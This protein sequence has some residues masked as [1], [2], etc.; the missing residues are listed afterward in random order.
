M[1]ANLNHAIE[2]SRHGKGSKH[3]ITLL[4]D[5]SNLTLW[6]A[7][8]IS[9]AKQLSGAPLLTRKYNFTKELSK[10]M[11]YGHLLKKE[12]SEVT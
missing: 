5:K 2:A 12:K 7:S 1:V 9:Y 11:G 4:P 3:I 10:S 8:V 6:I